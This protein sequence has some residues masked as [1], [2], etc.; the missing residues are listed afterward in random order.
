MSLF[1]EMYD[2][3]VIRY[4]T[5]CKERKGINRMATHFNSGNDICA[6]HYKELSE[7]E[8]TA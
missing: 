3:T 4:C 8:V 6:D 1:N 7:S 2:L 5:L